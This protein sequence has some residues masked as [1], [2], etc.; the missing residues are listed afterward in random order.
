MLGVIKALISRPDQHPAAPVWLC[1]LGKVNNILVPTFPSC[2][3]KG[4]LFP[5]CTGALEINLLS[6]T[7]GE[8][9]K[10]CMWIRFPARATGPYFPDSTWS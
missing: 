3:R 10:K 7:D 1:N 6:E 2:K 8:Y 5:C 9:G 4:M